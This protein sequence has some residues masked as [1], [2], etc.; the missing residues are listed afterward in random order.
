MSPSASPK[1]WTTSSNISKFWLRFVLPKKP[2]L[3][4][5]H[6]REHMYMSVLWVDIFLRIPDQVGLEK[7]V[8]EAEVT[9][10]V[11][12]CQ[13]ATLAPMVGKRFE[14]GLVKLKM[15]FWSMSFTFFQSWSIHMRQIRFATC[16]FVTSCH[17]PWSGNN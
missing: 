12:V 17:S 13:K 11:Q 16:L 4:V 9:S 15:N 6:G 3:H 7:T 2:C 14:Q 8:K 10:R 1:V 5:E